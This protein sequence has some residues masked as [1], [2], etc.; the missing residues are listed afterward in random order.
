MINRRQVLIAL[1]LVLAGAFGIAAWMRRSFERQLDRETGDLL[2]AAQAPTAI[3]VSE[4]DLE[5]LP[6][7]VQ[8]WLRAS[9]VV[10]SRV[11]AVVRIQQRGEFRLGANKPWMPLDATQ[12]YTTNPPGF[13]W[14]ASM[15]MMPMVDVNGRD[16]Y[17]EGTGDIEM[18]VASIYPVAKKSGGNLNSGALLRYLNEAMWFPA[19]LV[20]PNVTWEPVDESSARATLSDAGQSVSAIFVFDERDRQVTM[21]AER[22]NDAEQA[23]RPWSTPIT[24]WGTFEGISMAI[25]GTGVWGTGDDAYEYV[26]VGLT[27]V[28]YDP[29]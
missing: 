10:G 18:R 21:T 4:S 14:N 15:Q 5:P 16:R 8:R 2:A 28:E 19:A 13:L 6:A 22:W 27:S 7:P 17:T 3:T 11:P 23:M 26:R 9:G 12:T 24:A 29:D 20:L 25:S 1:G